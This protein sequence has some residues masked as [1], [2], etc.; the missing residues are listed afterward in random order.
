[1]KRLF[2]MFLIAFAVASV[3]W[4]DDVTELEKKFVKLARESSAKTVGIKSFIESMGR[5]GMGSGAIISSDGYILTCDH[6]VPCKENIE[7]LL[8]DGRRFQAKRV[9]TCAKNDFALLKIDAKDLPYFELGDSGSL[10]IDDWVAAL[11]HPGGLRDDNQPTFAVGRVAG[12]NKKLLAMLE[13]Y[14][15]DAIQTDIPIS[16]GNSGGP[17]VDIEGRLVGINGAAMPIETRSYATPIN[18]IKSVL[19]QMKEGKDVQGE[20]PKNIMEVV[21]EMYKDLGSDTVQKVI[22]KLAPNMDKLMEQLKEMT[23]GKDLSEMLKKLFGDNK[24]MEEMFKKFFGEDNDFGEMLKELQKMF[25]NEDMEKLLEEFQKMFKG[26]DIQKMLD[27][28]MKKF[29]Q[30]EEGE[31]PFKAMREMFK[32]FM[33]DEQIQKMLK[34]F[35]KQ[36]GEENELQKQIEKMMEEMF[37]KPRKEESPEKRPSEGAVPKRGKI[38]LGV[39]VENVSDEIKYQ[40]KLDGGVIVTDIREG[41]PADKAGLKKGD[42]ILEING[43]PITRVSDMAKAF[44]GIGDGKEVKLKI[45]QAGEKKEVVVKIPEEKPVEEPSPQK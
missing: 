44:E 39:K 4:A 32:E 20:S 42:I 26:N 14:Y 24:N 22:K 41:S 15:P 35:M 13:K 1:M 6:V 9:A 23:G 10:K 3:L 43:T 36:F 11:G 5:Y 16:P 38:R 30:P 45:L 25:K 21:S 33:K 31:D 18:R 40:L 28:M 29:M 8:P 34:E 12:I 37:G 19:D 27:E 17:L 7:V 2:A